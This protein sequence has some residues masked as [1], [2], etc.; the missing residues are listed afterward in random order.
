MSATQPWSL[1]WCDVDPSRRTLDLRPA[2]EIADRLLPRAATDEVDDELEDAIDVEL[3]RA[4]GFWAAGWR[5]ALH[6]GG[7]VRAWCCSRDSLPS[8]RDKDGIARALADWNAWLESVRAAFETIDRETNGQSPASRIERAAGRILALVVERTG[9]EDA[10]YSTFATT[11]GW[12]I[13]RIDPNAGVPR[14]VAEI[15]GGRFQSWLEPAPD[16]AGRVC[17]DIGE[18]MA[19]QRPAPATEDALAQWCALRR[20]TWGHDRLHPP[21]RVTNDG[22]LAYIERYDRARDVIRAERMQGALMQ[23]RAAAIR[24]EPLEW[25][26]LARCQRSVLGLDA[27]PEFRTADAFA[28]NGHERYAV[29]PGGRR[30]FERCLAEANDRKIV[31]GVAARVYLDVCFFHPFEDGNARAA[32][33]ALDW[34]LTRAGLALHVAEPIFALP[35]W[36]DDAR[37]MTVIVVLLD[38][39]TGT[40]P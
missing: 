13:E 36:A 15:V 30:D 19:A 31:L 20:S 38:H 9:C 12:Y 35:R 10:W 8:A 22:H 3:L 5:W 29:P 39:L 11:L 18:R 1:R 14:R 24:D 16:V 40:R 23:I 7:P 32:R 37:A 25:A 4:Y 33:L 27:D 2:R 26:L 21:T 6:D 28:K 34:V 17:V